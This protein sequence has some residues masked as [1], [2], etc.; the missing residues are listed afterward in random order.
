MSKT[1]QADMNPSRRK[2][3]SSTASCAAAS[4]VAQETFGSEALHRISSP[5]SHSLQFEVRNWCTNL[6]LYSQI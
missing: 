3:L 1:E 5:D 6:S 4:L 2:F